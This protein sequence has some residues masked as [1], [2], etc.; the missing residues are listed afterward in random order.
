MASSL[1]K[2]SG[3]VNINTT[4]V[5]KIEKR[6]EEVKEEKKKALLDS[7]FEDATVL[8]DEGTELEKRLEEERYKLTEGRELVEVTLDHLS[9]VISKISNVPIDNIMSSDIEKIRSMKSELEKKII[10]Q[11]EAVKELT[12]ALQ[13]NMF[14][15]RDPNKPIASFLLVGSTG[16]GKTLISKLVAKEFMGSE[17]NLITIACSEYMQDWAESKLLG[18][19]PGYVGYTDSEPRLYIL[20][21]KPYS[22]ILIDEVEKSSSNLYNIWLNMLEEGEITL[23][24]GEKVSCRNS[25]IIFTGNVGTKTLEL[26]GNGIGFSKP[27]ATQKRKQEVATVMAEVKKEFR[28]EF[29]NR[30]S[31]VVVFNSLTEKELGQIFYLE[32]GKVKDRIKENQGF[33]LYVS[34][35]VK[36]LIVSKCELQYGARGLQ[37]LITEYIEDNINLAMLHEDITGKN[38]IYLDVS[39]EDSE[40]IE[41]VFK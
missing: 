31:K 22:V 36:D 15:L 7:R 24:S 41:V 33:N 9:S 26:R 34:E 38:N 19:A 14:G 6:L 23:S 12:L 1:A 16:V 20:K 27:D 10:G 21:R 4:E 18:S 30:I 3:E 17:S 28:P 2:L 37:R 5:S 39:K 8:R 13:R 11:D 40:G 32:L 25:I 35:K 29:L